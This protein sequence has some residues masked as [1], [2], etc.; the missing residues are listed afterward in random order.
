MRLCVIVADDVRDSADDDSCL[1]GPGT[2]KNQQ[3]TVE[4]KNR[5]ALFGIECVEEM[6]EPAIFGPVAETGDTV[7]A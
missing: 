4:V 1:A 2:G 3:R 7:S 6:H 5:L